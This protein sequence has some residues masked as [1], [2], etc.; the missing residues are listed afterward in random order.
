MKQRRRFGVGA[1][2]AA[3]GGLVLSALLGACGR[4]EPRDPKPAGSG[5]AAAPGPAVVPPA[6]G[7]G[8]TPSAGP[9]GGPG[10]TATGGGSRATDGPT[11]RG[12]DATR[13]TDATGARWYEQRESG[14]KLGWIRVVWA[15]STWEGTPTI[16]DTTTSSTRQVRQMME[17]E[18]EF[19]VESTT[20]VERGLDGALYAMRTVSVENAAR[21]SVAEL[22]W[23]GKGYVSRHTSASPSNAARCRSTARCTWIRRPALRSPV[24]AGKVKV[25]TGSSAASSTCAARR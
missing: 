17:T 20:E 2:L 8:S 21:T 22:R 7:T 10:G 23:T 9:A 18:D 3:L 15:P 19:G 6:A 12:P 16:H 5:A 4:D 1:A 25:G 13:S 24:A 11:R 14:Q